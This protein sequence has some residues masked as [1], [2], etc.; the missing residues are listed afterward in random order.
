MIEDNIP[1][2]LN[3]FFFYAHDVV[4]DV[5]LEVETKTVYFS[6]NKDYTDPLKRYEEF[7]SKH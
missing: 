4:V 6:N 7:C 5:G 2:F 3:Q 1:S